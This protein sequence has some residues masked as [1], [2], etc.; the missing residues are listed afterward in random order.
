[1]GE[2]GEASS[3]VSAW[4]LARAS[5][6]WGHHREQRAALKQTLGRRGMDAP[7]LSGVQIEG[8]SPHFQPSLKLYN[9]LYFRHLCWKCFKSNPAVIYDVFVLKKKKK[10]IIGIS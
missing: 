3:W 8:S 6:P 5:P 9:K 1:M 4:L 10:G 7:V 2:A